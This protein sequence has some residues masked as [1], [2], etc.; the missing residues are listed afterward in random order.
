MKELTKK[1]LRFSLVLLPV[2]VI[3]IIF[4][5]LY[6][7]EMFPPEILEEAIKQVGSKELII[8]I[9]VIQSTVYTFICSFIGYIVAEKT[10]L[11]KAF[12]IKT[13][14]LLKA[15]AASV[16]MGIIFSLDYWIFGSIIN[17]VKEAT[18][19]G[20]S[21]YGVVASVLYGG[22]IEEIMMRLFLMSL[23]TLIIWKL[24]FKP[25][26]KENIPT[27]V[28]LFA[29]IVTAIL[30]AAAHLPATLQTFGALT[31][32]ILF[33]CFLLNGVFGFVFGEIYRKYGLSYAM[34][35][36]AATH[37]V[38]KLILFIFI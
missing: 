31:P 6:Q 10:G 26:P 19:A 8:V 37:I 21:F 16:L 24:F 1:A 30:F 4:T 3:A 12:S 27:K 13:D 35:S 20:L 2:A 11:L 17:G 18:V 32:M 36:H 15:L 23:I 9:S 25:I 29:N 33:R 5:C 34:I 38:C 22:I 28:F 14:K 7:F